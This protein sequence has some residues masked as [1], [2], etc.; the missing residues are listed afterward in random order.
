M[1]SGRS[2]PPS[3]ENGALTTGL[4]CERLEH[5]SILHL[6]FNWEASAWVAESNP[7]CLAQLCV[8]KGTWKRQTMVGKARH[9]TARHSQDSRGQG[10]LGGMCKTELWVQARW[11]WLAR[12]LATRAVPWLAAHDG[13]LNASPEVLAASMELKGLLASQHK[14][15]PWGLEH[16]SAS[17]ATGELICLIPAESFNLTRMDR[18]EALF[19]L[20][21]RDKILAS[22]EISRQC[23]LALQ[24]M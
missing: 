18:C 6:C 8:R 24:G 16:C 11:E 20:L 17:F 14:G 2:S 13:Q 15:V 19:P 10:G 7:S 12:P 21:L 22:G 23:L 4:L 5:N 3:E 1:A 9:G